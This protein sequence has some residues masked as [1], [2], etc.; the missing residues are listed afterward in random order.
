MMPTARASWNR[1]HYCVA[2]V[3]VVFWTAETLT[4]RLLLAWAS[5][6]YAGLLVWPEV[7]NALR[8][9]LLLALPALGAYL[10]A[11]HP[12]I[13]SRP[14]YALMAVAP[15]GVWFW[16]ALFVAHW[17]G[18]HWRVFDPVER[19]RWSLA[20]NVLG[21]SI[22]FY[23]TVSLI[24]AIGLAT[25]SVGLEIVVIWFSFWVMV[26]TGINSGMLSE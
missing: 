9:V 17:L 5:V 18:V 22:W 23:S 13:F 3:R 12:S 10:P 14:A 20:V 8:G 19:D 2:V 24:V 16:F 25:P 21:L 11:E 4:V 6:L 1:G 26:R 15:G 7:F